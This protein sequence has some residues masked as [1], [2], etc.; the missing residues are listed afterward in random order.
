MSKVSTII[1]VY[2]DEMRTFALCAV[3]VADVSSNQRMWNE[4]KKTEKID[5]TECMLHDLN[6]DH[7]IDSFR[8]V[9]IKSDYRFFCW[10]SSISI[11]VDLHHLPFLI[12]KEKKKNICSEY[13]LE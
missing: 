8:F 4:K 5:D 2:L 9:F 10:V 12:W 11:R 13:N 7:F 1:H 3:T 6:F